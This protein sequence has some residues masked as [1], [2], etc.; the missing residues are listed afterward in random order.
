MSKLI[1]EEEA[2]MLSGI[3]E[4]PFKRKTQDSPAKRPF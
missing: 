1:E 3:Q 2:K 4:D